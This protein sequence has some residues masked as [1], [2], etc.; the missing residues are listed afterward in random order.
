MLKLSWIY[1]SLS[2]LCPCCFWVFYTDTNR[3]FIH[4]FNILNITTQRLTSA[5]QYY[6]HI[7]FKRSFLLEF[8]LHVS[9]CIVLYV[10]FFCFFFFF[11]FIS[12]WDPC[13]CACVAGSCGVALCPVLIL[14]GVLLGPLSVVLC[15]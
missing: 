7:N 9:V 10:F 3:Y 11:F 12:C 2:K 4:T 13:R 8:W 14:F 1:I 15:C 5:S 6:K